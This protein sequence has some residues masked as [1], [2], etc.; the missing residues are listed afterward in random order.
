[1]I[2]MRL[3]GEPAMPLLIHSLFILGAVLA[4]TGVVDKA[5]SIGET[6]GLTLSGPEEGWISGVSAGGVEATEVEELLLLLLAALLELVLLVLPL[7]LPLLLMLLHATGQPGTYYDKRQVMRTREDSRELS[8]CLLCHG[9][10]NA[11]TF[12]G[13]FPVLLGGWRKSHGQLLW[14]AEGSGLQDGSQGPGA[15]QGRDR[16]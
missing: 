6:A 8:S 2:L 16:R 1:M 3:P 15:V 10:G 13:M 7:S 4:D 11:A 14:Q 9:R 12:F 5:A